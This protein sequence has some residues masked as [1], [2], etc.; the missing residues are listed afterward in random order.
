MSHRTIASD[1]IFSRFWREI[2]KPLQYM[3]FFQTLSISYFIDQRKLLFSRKLATHNNSFLLSLSRLVQNRLYAIGSVYGCTTFLIQLVK[4]S[5][6]FPLSLQRQYESFVMYVQVSIF[7]FSLLSFIDMSACSFCIV[8]CL[9]FIFYFICIL[10]LLL[11]TWHI[12]PDD[13]DDD[14]DDQ[15]SCSSQCCTQSTS[16]K[17]PTLL[18][19][20]HFMCQN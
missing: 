20:A 2:V 10:F 15:S 1:I 7:S 16:F 6:S 4:S 17:Y 3:Y 14:D 12:K 8:V 11:P 19:P 13:D 5:R 9:Y 18:H